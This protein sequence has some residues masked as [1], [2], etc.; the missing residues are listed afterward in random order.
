MAGNTYRT[1]G[2]MKIKH[3]LIYDARHQTTEKSTFLGDLPDGEMFIVNGECY[4]AN[5]LSEEDCLYYRM[6][7]E[8]IYKLYQ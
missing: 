5:D 7:A 1:I 3:C 6:S 8:T 2:V 4:Y